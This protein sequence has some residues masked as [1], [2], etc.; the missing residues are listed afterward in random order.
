MLF[1]SSNVCE[2]TVLENE[3]HKS[4]VLRL[5]QVS[6]ERQSSSQ[7]VV[8][9]LFITSSSESHGINVSSFPLMVLKG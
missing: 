5:Q 9:G 8:G 2:L 3:I 7:P 4:F 1:I 6:L